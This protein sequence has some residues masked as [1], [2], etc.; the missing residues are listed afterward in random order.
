VY[1]KRR[2]N[3]TVVLE[4][5]VPRRVP[6]WDWACPVRIVGLGRR[7]EK[8]EP[9]F[10]IDAVQAMQLAI[11]YARLMLAPHAHRLTGT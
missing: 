5:G 2:A 3:G 10:A 1:E 11:E 6:G 4:I 7:L 8:V 9:V